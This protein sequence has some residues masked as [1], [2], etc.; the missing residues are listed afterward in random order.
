MSDRKDDEVRQRLME[1]LDFHRNY[2]RVF[3]MDATDAATRAHIFRLRDA[4]LT[5]RPHVSGEHLGTCQE[6]A[7]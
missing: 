5:C 3:F 4:P 7:P 6:P 2:Q 1:N